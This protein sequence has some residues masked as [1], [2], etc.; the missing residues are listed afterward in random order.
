MEQIKDSFKPLPKRDPQKF[1]MRHIETEIKQLKLAID[2]GKNVLAWLCS[3]ETKDA[4][5]A[6]WYTLQQQKNY[7]KLYQIALER[8]EKLI[9]SQPIEDGAKCDTFKS[10]VKVTKQDL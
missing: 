10:K 1:I 3:I 6:H 5:E 7:E 9:S 4:A 2:T 8:Y